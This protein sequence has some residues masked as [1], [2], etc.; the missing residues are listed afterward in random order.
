MLPSTTVRRCVRR[1]L[2]CG[3]EHVGGGVGV[4]LDAGVGVPVGGAG[5]GVSVDAG[6]GVP[7]AGAGVDVSVN[8]GMGVPVAGTGVGVSVAGT[9]VFV[10]VEVFRVMV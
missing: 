4:A 9:G 10:G 8:C 6:V 3:N 1:T 7:V 2:R 5:V